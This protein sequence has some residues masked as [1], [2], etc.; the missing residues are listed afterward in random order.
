MMGSPIIAAIAKATRWDTH[1]PAELPRLSQCD[2]VPCPMRERCI[3]EREK[4][5]PANG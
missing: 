3:E 5:N 4:R 2:K 1:C